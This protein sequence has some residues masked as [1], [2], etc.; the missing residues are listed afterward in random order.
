MQ[1]IVSRILENK[2]IAEG[3]Y[4]MTLETEFCQFEAPGQFAMVEVPGRF[5]RRPISVS[6]Y[7]S[8]RYTLVYKV[9]GKGTLDMSRMAASEEVDALTGLGNGYDVSAIPDGAVIVGGGI[10]IPPML[11]LVKQLVMAGKSCW[12]VLGFNRAE[13]MFMVDDFRMF[14]NDL[15]IMTADGSRGRKGFVTDAFDHVP[16]ICACGP[17][18]MLKALRDKCDGGQFSLEARMGCGFGACMGCSIETTEGPRR[19]CKE[20]PVFDK[21]VVLWE[22]I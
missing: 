7:D 4:K 22:R 1:D 2:K 15:T 13:E 10:G 5:L 21:E 12:V 14:T 9:V 11:G 19:I 3:V 6:E 17:L 8:G 16:Y 18:P 20:G